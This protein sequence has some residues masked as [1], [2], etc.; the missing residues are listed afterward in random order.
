M[1]TSTYNPYETAQAQFDKVASLLDL[2]E[3]TCQLLRQPMREYHLS[4]PVRMDDGSVKVF[5]GYAYSTM[6]QEV[7]L[8]GASAFI[9]WRLS[10]PF[11]LCQCG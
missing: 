7:R 1:S 5:N 11:E 2:D 8:K 3:A 6:M 4:I 9:R 10:I